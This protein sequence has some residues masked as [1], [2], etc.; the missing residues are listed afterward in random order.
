GLLSPDGDIRAAIVCIDRAERGREAQFDVRS[1]ALECRNPADQPTHG[2]G[3]RRIDAQNRPSD[4]LLHVHR[5]QRQP[6]EN[7]GHLSKIDLPGIGQAELRWR[8]AKQFYAEPVLQK[9]DLPA[10]RPVRDVQF[11]R[12]VGE[13]YVPGRRFE[14][15]NGIERWQFSHALSRPRRCSCFATV[16]W[17]DATVA[18]DLERTGYRPGTGTAT[19]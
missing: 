8:P 17:S 6:V 12:G 2:E 3:R 18:G 1:L 15:P 19:Q 16:D 5:G 9:R 10:Y 14:G 4:M 11:F 7:G 13:A